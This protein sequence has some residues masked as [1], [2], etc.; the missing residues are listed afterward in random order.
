MIQPPSIMI[1]ASPLGTQNVRQAIIS[2]DLSSEQRQSIAE[3]ILSYVEIL[4][5]NR[6]GYLDILAA[7]M[8][9]NAEADEVMFCDLDRLTELRW[10]NA[11]RRIRRDNRKLR[12]TLQLIQSGENTGK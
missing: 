12:N 3:M 8:L 6:V 11:G 4:H 1:T 5:G 2:G 9:Y 10:W 7:N